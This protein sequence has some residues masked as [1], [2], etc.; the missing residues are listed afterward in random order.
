MEHK[1]QNRW[2]QFLASGAVNDY[3][4]Y[5]QQAAAEEAQ[6]ETVHQRIDYT[7]AS[8]GGVGSVGNRPHP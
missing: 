4:A 5:R 3:L 7:G 6:D 1:A 8:G 2:A